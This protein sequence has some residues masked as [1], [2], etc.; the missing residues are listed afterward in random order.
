MT[1]G[2]IRAEVSQ[3]YFRACTASVRCESQQPQRV[4]AQGVLLEG[5]THSSCRP[6]PLTPTSELPPHLL[7]PAA[8][9]L[10]GCP[11]HSP[12]TA[13]PASHSWQTGSRPGSC[14]QP[15]ERSGPGD[16]GSCRDNGWGGLCPDLGRQWRWTRSAGGSLLLHGPSIF[17]LLFLSTPTVPSP[18]LPDTQSILPLRVSTCLSQPPPSSLCCT[19]GNTWLGVGGFHWPG[20]PWGLG[21]EEGLPFRR[22][23][24]CHPHHCQWRTVGRREQTWGPAHT[25]PTTPPLPFP[26][27]RADPHLGFG[28]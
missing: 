16:W 8:R 11:G 24:D 12:G 18:C 15:A 4:T 7:A 19:K 28:W 14:L 1:Q 26:Q 17:P 25:M 23:Q 9:D 20:E 6:S 2:G 22:S 5:P 21:A 27:P 13:A 3:G 10:R